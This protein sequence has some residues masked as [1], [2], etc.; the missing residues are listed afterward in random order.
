MGNCLILIIDMQNGFQNANTKG[1]DQKILRFLDRLDAVE[2]DYNGN[3]GNSGKSGNFEK[4]KNS[5]DSGNSRKSENSADIGKSSDSRFA[6]ILV[7]GT[8]YVNHEQT[9]CYRFEGWKAC[10]AGT[11]EAQILDS[12]RPRMQRVFQKDKYSCWNAQMQQYIR[13]N[14]I[15]KVY[16]AGV[17][18]G[19]CVLHSAFDF[20]NDLVD[21]S[22]IADLCGS[23]SGVREHEAALIVLKSCITKERVITAEEAVKEIQAAIQL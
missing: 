4:S 23:T 13:E 1:L 15:K 12:L 2:S 22:V 16:F 11:K 19:C 8:C 14:K 18:T 21:C 20:Y 10:M 7:A 6:H 5:T 9:A 3:A 17:N